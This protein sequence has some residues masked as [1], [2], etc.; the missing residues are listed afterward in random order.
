MTYTVEIVEGIT[1][2]FEEFEKAVAFIELAV[3]QGY[4]VSICGEVEDY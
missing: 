2:R 1:F 3:A 4:K